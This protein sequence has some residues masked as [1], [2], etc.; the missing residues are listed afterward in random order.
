MQLRR[1]VPQVWALTALTVF[2]AQLAQAQP[3]PA[4]LSPKAQYAAD[5]KVAT[6]R[7]KDDLKICD[8]SPDAG[9]RMQ[10]KRDAKSE[11]DKALATAKARMG[12]AGKPA[13]AALACPECGTVVSVSQIERQGEGSALG[14]IVGGV[15]GALLGNQIGR[16]TGRDLA[17]LAGAA[18]GAYAGREVEKRVN[19]HKSWQVAV[20]YPHG[21]TQHYEFA[22][23]PG[24]KVGEPVRPSDKT[25]VRP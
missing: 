4:P 9:S 3:E 13:A 12:A 19:T 2:T 10:C 21:E 15:G 6:A 1:C 5:S 25:I 8:A 18:G 11:H 14:M 23:N 16:G 22:Q 24:F 7:Y 20:R 17:T